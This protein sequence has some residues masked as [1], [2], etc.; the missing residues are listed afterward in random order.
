MF[1]NK[2]LTVATIALNA[3]SIAFSAISFILILLNLVIKASNLSLEVKSLVK[4]ISM[5][6]VYVFV[7]VWLATQ[8]LNII[9]GAVSLIEDKNNLKEFI[10]LIVGTILGIAIISLIGSIMLYKKYFK[11]QQAKTITSQQTL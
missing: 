10:L 9:L 5:L 6:P 2:K 8:I 1:K 4:S 11:K 3:V 7:F